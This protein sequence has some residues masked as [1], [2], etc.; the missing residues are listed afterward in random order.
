[1]GLISGTTDYD[2]DSPGMTYDLK[3][4]A[5]YA[6]MAEW[7]SAADYATRVKPL[8]GLGAGGTVGGLNGSAYPNA[9]T[10]RDDGAADFLFGNPP[11]MDWFFVSAQ[12]VVRGAR[13]GDVRTAV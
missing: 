11:H 7:G 8:L 9:A 13:R 12:D 1:M 3:L 5:L 4:S 6:L 10:V 2:T